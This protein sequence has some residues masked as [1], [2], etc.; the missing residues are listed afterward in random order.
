[1]ATTVAEVH[2]APGP[3]RL[4]GT[5]R[6]H[7]L[8]RWIFV[9]MA[10]WYI[11]IALAG[12]IP[13]SLMKLEM[14][15]AGARPAFPLILH[16]H[17]VLMGSFLLFLLSQTVLVAT[18][19]CIVHRRIGPLGGVLAAALV[20]VGFI[21]APTMY[22]QVWGAAHFGPP[23]V[24]QAM[25]PVVQLLDNILL[26]QIG[27]GLLFAAV[28]AI[29]IKQR[30]RN[31]GFHKRMMMMAPAAALPAAFD[32]MTWI[33]TT[34]PASPTSAEFYV[35]LAIAP[36]FV[37]DVIRNGRVHRAY[38]VFLL[39]FAPIIIAQQ[40]LWDTPWWHAMAP[41]IMGV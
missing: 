20:V 3:D 34:F 30:D 24:A 25:T 11:A 7:A 29:G 17:A 8:D 33:P 14:V 23:E 10:V 35:L 36:L 12:F 40:M 38:G 15:R 28:L 37:W 26:L 9:A 5:P 18:G 19:H 6:A 16:I 32:R 22:G 4:L 39:I 41:R 1:M 31:A 13:D 21:L 2:R 27:A